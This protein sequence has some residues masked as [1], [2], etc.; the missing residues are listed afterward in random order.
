MN[1]RELRCQ[2]RPQYFVGYVHREHDMS[3]L[4]CVRADFDYKCFNEMNLRGAHLRLR[5]YGMSVRI[6]AI[7]KAMGEA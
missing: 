1:A 7:K 2:Q 6:E 3:H 5:L 4:W